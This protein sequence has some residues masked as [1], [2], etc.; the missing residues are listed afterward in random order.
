MPQK[1]W[2]AICVPRQTPMEPKA[3]PTEISLIP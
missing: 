1:V 3:R 2:I